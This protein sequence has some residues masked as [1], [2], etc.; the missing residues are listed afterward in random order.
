MAVALGTSWKGSPR[1]VQGTAAGALVAGLAL[2]GPFADPR[3]LRSSFLHHNDFVAFYRPRP[4]AIREVP[5]LYRR[6]RGETVAEYP[7][8]IVWD[9]NRT[10]YLYQEVHGGRVIV[11]TP[12]RI[13]FRPPLA[14]RNAV[15][16]D[17]DALCRSG[18]RY[19]IVHLNVAR[20]EDR[21]APGGRISD[22]ALSRPLRHAFR[23]GARVL[24]NQLA[25]RWGE[26]AYADRWLRAWDLPAVCGKD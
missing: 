2:A 26:P 16:P 5:E 3:L 6:L 22:F 14:L 4:P 21:L 1:F 20:E 12:Q 25:R 19:L 18:A 11:A 23:D 7:W 10:F 24:S 9:S 15:A 17:P 13:L 8:V